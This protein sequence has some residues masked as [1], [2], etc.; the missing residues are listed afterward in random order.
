MIHSDPVNT[1]QPP[2]NRDQQWLIGSLLTLVARQA[3]VW[4]TL[5]L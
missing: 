5:G 4:M 1:D 2:D 3:A